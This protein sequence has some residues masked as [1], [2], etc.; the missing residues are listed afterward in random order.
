[1]LRLY[2]RHIPHGWRWLP[3]CIPGGLVIKLPGI[4]PALS[5]P[6]RKMQGYKRE[7]N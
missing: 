1:M 7:I 5:M 4:S 6:A 3:A 2:P